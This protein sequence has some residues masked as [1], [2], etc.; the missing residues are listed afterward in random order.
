M[1]QTSVHYFITFQPERK[2]L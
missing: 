1:L 2:C